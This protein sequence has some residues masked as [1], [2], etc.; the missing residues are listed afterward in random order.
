MT[1]NNTLTVRNVPYS[2]TISDLLECNGS[3]D[4]EFDQMS[5]SRKT[6]PQ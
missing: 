3:S 5:V 2:T 6:R 1:P 4:W